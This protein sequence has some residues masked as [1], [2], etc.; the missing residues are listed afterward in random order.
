MKIDFSMI[1]LQYLI[2]ARD[3]AREDPEVAA[4]V[5]GLSKEL[6]VLLAQ[7]S[8]Q[9]LAKIAQ[10]KVPLLTVR[11]DSWWWSRLFTALTDG[12]AE[13]ID[14]ILDHASLVVLS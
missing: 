11:G 4:T 14:I 9:C 5:L 3:I 10:I 1:N 12:G 8:S 13:E 6:A 2:H 7:T